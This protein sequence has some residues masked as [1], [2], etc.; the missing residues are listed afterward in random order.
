MGAYYNIVISP[1][2]D[3]DV[4][5][6]EI[7]TFLS[8]RGLRLME[9][10][11]L[12]SVDISDHNALLIS[13]PANGWVEIVTG[14]GIGID[15]TWYAS[16]PL[17]SFVSASLRNCIHIWSL[18]SGRVAGY[19]VYADGKNEECDVVFSKYAKNT[20]ELMD[21][22]PT[23]LN[24]PGQ[25]LK[26]LVGIDFRRFMACHG[27]LENG[28]GQLVAQIGFQVHLV[29]YFD[30]TDDKQGV[31]VEGSTYEPVTLRGWTAIR[32]ARHEELGKD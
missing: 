17:A 25:L 10:A 30:A 21:G 24:R 15:S 1:A 29:D 5:V 32:F 19:A 16:N 4:M 27:T 18:N 12:E 9:V 31:A 11:A 28:M 3:Y 13:P 14:Q 22:V 23:P 2:C 20:S 26:S 6:R 8:M 7:G